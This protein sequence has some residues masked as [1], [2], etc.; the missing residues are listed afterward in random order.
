M[1][2]VQLLV[3][4]ISTHPC[5]IRQHFLPRPAQQPS[6]APECPPLKTS[7]DVCTRPRTKFLQLRV[8]R[9]STNRPFELVLLDIYKPSLFDQTSHLLKHHD[10]FAHDLKDFLAVLDPVAHDVVVGDGAVL[11]VEA[12]REL[13]LFDPAARLEGAV[14]F[15]VEVRPGGDT[16]EEGADVDKVDG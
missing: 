7:I 9:P 1:N 4:H 8:L 15:G 3:S 10:L 13:G 12:G 14:A 5:A 11:G 6:Q 2:A 16:A